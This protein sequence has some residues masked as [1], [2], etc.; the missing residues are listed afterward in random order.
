RQAKLG[1]AML[2]IT[3]D[4]GILA[5]MADE[6]VGIYHGESMEAGPGEAIFRNPQHPYLRGLMAAVPH[7][8]MKPCERLK[9]RREVTV[10]LE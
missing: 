5:N 7:C 1:M 6:V 8:D 10:N 4:I 3:H 2:L 9:A